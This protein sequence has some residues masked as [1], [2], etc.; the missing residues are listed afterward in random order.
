MKAWNPISIFVLFAIL[1][2]IKSWLLRDILVSPT[3][4]FQ[5]WEEAEGKLWTARNP[6]VFYAFM[7]AHALPVYNDKTDHAAR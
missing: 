1:F 3:K 7:N 5:L 2:L 6:M 4:F